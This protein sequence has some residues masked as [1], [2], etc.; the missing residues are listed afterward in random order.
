MCMWWVH[1]SVLWISVDTTRLSIWIVS[2]L[3]IVLRPNIYLKKRCFLW[4]SDDKNAAHVTVCRPKRL[5]FVSACHKS[6][7]FFTIYPKHVLPYSKEPCISQSVQVQLQRSIFYKGQGFC[8]ASCPQTLILR[9][10]SHWVA[11]P[12]SVSSAHQCEWQWRTE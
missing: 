1:V 7:I 10:F 12:H 2:W 4:H 3:S 6:D 11:L 9:F 5:W 8:F